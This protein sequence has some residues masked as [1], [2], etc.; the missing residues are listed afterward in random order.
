MGWLTFTYGWFLL[1]ALSAAI[2]L[3]LH[4]RYRKKAPRIEF[5][6]IRFLL[7]SVQKTAHRRR[8]YELIILLLRCGTLFL[9]A[10]GLAGPV[11]RTGGLLGKGDTTL[12]LIVDN[13]YSMDVASDGKTRYAVAKE[14]A[15]DAIRQ[16]SPSSKVVVLF[17]NRRPA[18]AGGSVE[19][20]ATTNK[21]RAVAEIEASEVSAAE[22]DI[23][24]ALARA[25]EILDETPNPNREIYVVS[26]LQKTAWKAVKSEGLKYPVVTLDCSAKGARN[27]ALADVTLHS[28]GRAT[29]VPLTIQAKLVNTADREEPNVNVSLFIDNVRR[30]QRTVDL[31]SRSSAV[32]SFQE[33]F[34]TPGVRAGWAQVELDDA[35]V[36]DNKRFF[37]VDV[38]ERIAALLVKEAEGAAPLLDDLFYL[39]PALDPAQ[40]GAGARS[41]IQPAIILRQELAQ[42]QLGRF[43]VVMLANCEELTA[44]EASRLED[45]VRRGGCVVFF[46]GDR[47]KPEA[48]NKLVKGSGPDGEGLAPAALGEAVGRAEDRGKPAHLDRLDEDHPMMAPFKGLP[49]SVLETVQVYRFYEL[50]APE[51]SRT[52][53]LAWM[54][55]DKPFLVYRRLGAGHTFLFCA[56]ANVAWTNLPVRVLFLP[57]LHQIVYFA[58]GTRDESASLL[59]GA[60]MTFPVEGR[61]QKVE[62]EV[63]DPLGRRARLPNPLEEDA[64]DGPLRYAE[65]FE[66]GVYTWRTLKGGAKQGAFVVNA[67]SRES[68][69]DAYSREE[70]AKLLSGAQV[71]FA[72]S[73]AE[74]RDL[75]LR[76]RTGIQLWNLALLAVVGIAIAE[77]FMANRR[78]GMDP[79]ASAGQA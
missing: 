5:P 10:A 1:G 55:N 23:A 63:T 25:K 12:A 58:A 38:P 20:Q 62:I 79:V 60:P 41:V 14:L 34:E 52:R 39:A 75:A 73:V 31:S 51:G 11:M 40:A 28:K 53:A 68:E 2:P 76:M 77:C 18:V 42:T 19:G 47:V 21:E 74:C 69:L 48:Y 9:L 16:L 35:L 17:T 8:I 59:A 32:V 71:Y 72:G 37:A 22:G 50:L 44:T 3:Y 4:M 65:T 70:V 7:L 78:Q 46:L 33:V 36:Y 54:D 26:D 43:A 30:A 66:R 29:G 56:T 15:Q 61:N 24:A 67:N 13:S 57:L 27:V 64:A 45:Y 6:T 49:R